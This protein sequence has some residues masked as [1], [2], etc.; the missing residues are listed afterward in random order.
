ME[1]LREGS[2]ALPVRLLQRLLNKRGASPRVAEDGVFGPGTRHA[3]AAFQRSQHLAQDGVVS[4]A[5]E[6]RYTAGW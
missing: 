6:V 1:I 2:R 5:L 4:V 3:V